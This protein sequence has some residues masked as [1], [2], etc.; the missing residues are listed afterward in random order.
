VTK[1]GP[2]ATRGHPQPARKA[3]RLAG[4]G[5]QRSLEMTENQTVEILF[6]LRGKG[7]W[8]TKAFKSQEAFEKWL[9][10]QPEDIEVR[11]AAR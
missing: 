11:F 9:A 3:S 4:L 6:H 8:K 7:G 5:R 2:G 1:E 10:K